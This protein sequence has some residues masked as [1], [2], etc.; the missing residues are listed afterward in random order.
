MKI[1][2]EMGEIENRKLRENINETE[3]FFE[4]TS[5]IDKPLER[6]TRNKRARCGGAHL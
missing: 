3:W 2:T 6:L 1:I 4:K 5:K